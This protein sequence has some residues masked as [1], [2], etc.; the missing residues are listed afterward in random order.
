MLP[1]L[2][3]IVSHSVIA[4]HRERTIL[5]AL[6]LAVSIANMSADKPKQ[7]QDCINVIVT[8]LMA[9][10]SGSS[11]MQSG[12]L[13]AAAKVSAVAPLFRR[14]ARGFSSAAE[15]GADQ[16]GDSVQR[17]K[18]YVKKLLQRMATNVS[19]SIKALDGDLSPTN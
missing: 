10:A 18:R 7:K 15:N 4:A 16:L 2:H 11:K 19:S 5:R 6:S 3:R 8:T 12:A 1:V 13:E 9:C 14:I 17:R